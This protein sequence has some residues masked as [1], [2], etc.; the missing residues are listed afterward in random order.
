MKP[1]MV[2]GL[3]QQPAE[4]SEERDWPLCSLNGPIYSVATAV[5]F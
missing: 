1:G 4:G 2:V 3:W 5:T